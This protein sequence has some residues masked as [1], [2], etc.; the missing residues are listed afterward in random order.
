M[1]PHRITTCPTCN[2]KVKI[3]G[4]KRDDPILACGHILNIEDQL[5]RDEVQNGITMAFYCLI[6]EEMKLK[7][8]SYKEAEAIIIKWFNQK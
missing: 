5:Q 8:I 2:Q 7:N 6:L 3:T 4:Y 1:F